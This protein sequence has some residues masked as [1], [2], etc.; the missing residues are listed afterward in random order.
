MSGGVVS[1]R[2]FVVLWF[3]ARRGAVQVWL[4]CVQIAVWAV[5]FTG[6]THWL[7]LHTCEEEQDK[8]FVFLIVP[9]DKRQCLTLFVCSSLHW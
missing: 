3:A 6:A 1:V 2:V 7:F 5:Q 9:S 8:Y 4:W